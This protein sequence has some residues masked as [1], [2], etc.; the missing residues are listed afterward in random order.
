MSDTASEYTK[1]ELEGLH[2]ISLQMAKVFVEFCKENDLTCYFCGGGCVGGHFE[3]QN[4]FI[5]FI[6]FIS[7]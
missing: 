4:E 7:S 5:K 3:K 2:R 1:E 6:R